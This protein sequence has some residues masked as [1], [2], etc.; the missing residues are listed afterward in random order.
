[1]LKPVRVY[2]RLQ[3]PGVYKFD[4]RDYP[5]GPNETQY[6]DPDTATHLAQTTAFKY[7]PAIGTVEMAIVLEGD[8]H[9]EQ[10]F[11][12]EVGQELLDRSTDPEPFVKRGIEERPRKT[13]YKKVDGVEADM[14]GGGPTGVFGK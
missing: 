12:G 9:F 3:T 11:E 4:G 2:H 10:P 7:D 13:V 14:K 5:F 6:L 8:P 1:M